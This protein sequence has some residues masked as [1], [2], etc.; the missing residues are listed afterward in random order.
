[1]YGTIVLLAAHVRQWL[2]DAPRAQAAMRVA[3]GM[4]LLVVA[5]WAGY[6]GWQRI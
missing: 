4:L 6:S 5:L 3:V 1:V 2:A